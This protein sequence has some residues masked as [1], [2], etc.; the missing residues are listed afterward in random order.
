M[1]TTA[2]LMLRVMLYV[3]VRVLLL[4]ALLKLTQLRTAH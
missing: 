1:F 2:L 4:Q 3:S